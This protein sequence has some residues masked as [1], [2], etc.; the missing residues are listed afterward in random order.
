MFDH[1]QQFKNVSWLKIKEIF[2][3]IMFTASLDNY[4]M[5]IKSFRIFLVYNKRCKWYKI[6]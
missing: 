2:N 6:T 5:T 1:V 3:E 4:A